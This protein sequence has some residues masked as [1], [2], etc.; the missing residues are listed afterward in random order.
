MLSTG[1]LWIVNILCATFI[2]AA[3]MTATASASAYLPITLAAFICFCALLFRKLNI[4]TSDRQLSLLEKFFLAY[5]FVIGGIRLAPY[6]WQYIASNLT[7]VST[8]DDYWHIQELA[9]LIT[10]PR[11]PPK[12]NF[13]P[14]SYLHFYYLP[15]LPSAAA[16]DVMQSIFGDPLI[17]LT[18]AI[19]SMALGIAASFILIAFV[20]HVL[21]PAQCETAL[22]AVIAMGAS[23][24][25]LFA[26]RD[27]LQGVSSDPEWWQTRLLI[28]ANFTMWTNLLVWV[29]HHLISAMAFLLSILIATEP[30]TLLIRESPLS[31]LAAGFLLGFSFFSS[32]FAFIG[33][34]IA[35]LPLFYQFKRR[36]T[37]L[38]IGSFAFVVPSLPLL[39]IYLHSDSKGGF[40]FFES[41]L[42]W[43]NHFSFVGAGIVGM[44]LAMAF[45]YLEIGWIFYDTIRNNPA[46]LRQSCLG[47]MAAFSAAFLV[48]TVF[49]S[50]KG[51]NNYA[52][53]GFIVPAVLVCCFWAGT[54]QGSHVR[55]RYFYRAIFILA[56]FGQFDVLTVFLKN[57]WDALFYEAENQTCKEAILSYSTN[58]SPYPDPMAL[59]H[60][61]N[62]SS[63]YLIERPFTKWFINEADREL[64]GR[65]P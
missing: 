21:A 52:I 10:S 47:G 16:S 29:P 9:S 22:L 13:F 61:S 14:S 40:L 63:I 41:Y 62:P 18:Y 26:L 54:M 3:L 19:G 8:V 12:L 6:S 59:K 53:R 1:L 24:E 20:R 48:S 38:A 31:F 60:C 37:Y 4:R 36:P 2:T 42:T 34:M 43:A 46:A 28:K 49:V 51:S 35:A 58:R 5:G 64:M 45:M 55:A 33:A 15:W 39:Y 23:V 27:F 50:F 65:G 44:V 17:K 7:G 11:F 25:G 56:V 30:K 32:V 57:S